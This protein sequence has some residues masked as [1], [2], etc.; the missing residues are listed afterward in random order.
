MGGVPDDAGWPGARGRRAARAA[1]APRHARAGECCVFGLVACP[2]VERWVWATCGA[3]A[4]WVAGGGGV[5]VA[6]AEAH[7]P[8]QPHGLRGTRV[9]GALPPLLPRSPSLPPRCRCRVWGR[10]LGRDWGAEAVELWERTGASLPALP[11]ERPETQPPPV[12]RWPRSHPPTPLFPPS[13]TPPPHPPHPTLGRTHRRRPGP[14]PGP[15]PPGP[16]RRAPRLPRQLC[17]LQAPGTHAHDAAT[18]CGA[19]PRVRRV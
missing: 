9:F 5:C 19:V 2:R 6:A 8:G 14:D 18:L 17:L 15:P 11:R 4:V 1:S 10:P 12:W 3:P 7:F 13:L 16:P